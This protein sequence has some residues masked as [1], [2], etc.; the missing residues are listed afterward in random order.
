MCYNKTAQSNLSSGCS[1]WEVGEGF[2]HT[3]IAVSPLSCGGPKTKGN[4]NT[5]F[6]HFQLSNADRTN[7]L[8]S[9]DFLLI[10]CSRLTLTM[11]CF[12]NIECRKTISGTS[13]LLIHPTHY[14]KWHLDCLLTFFLKY[15]VV[16]IC[17]SGLWYKQNDWTQPV[18]TATIAVWQKLQCG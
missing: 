4:K 13:D 6:Q 10:F 3:V 9:Y 18:L 12:W 2:P 7:W 17:Q 15:T 8:A 14:P 5:D 16:T 1:T 11:H